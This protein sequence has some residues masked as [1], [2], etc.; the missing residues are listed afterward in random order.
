MTTALAA[1][2]RFACIIHAQHLKLSCE[3]SIRWN[4]KI[5][6]AVSQLESFPLSCP[7][8]PVVPLVCFR[9]VPPNPERLRQLIIKPYRIVY[10]AVDDEVHVLSIRYGRMRV[11]TDDTYWNWRNVSDLF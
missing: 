9:D 5:L 7:V 10:E 2:G 11:P 6:N 4:D 1:F 3:D 8:V